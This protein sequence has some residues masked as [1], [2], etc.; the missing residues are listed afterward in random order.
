MTRPRRRGERQLRAPA[1]RY[2]SL[3]Q[4][5]ATSSMPSSFILRVSVLRPTQELGRVLLHAV[6]L[7]QSHADQNAFDLRT[8]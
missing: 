2:A 3:R 8:A 7:A 4:P 6:G 5:L 1:V